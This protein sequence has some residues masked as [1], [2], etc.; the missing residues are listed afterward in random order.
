MGHDVGDELLKYVAARI[1][2]ILRKPDILARIGGDEFA[3][4]LHDTSEKD[5]ELVVA[6]I[7]DNVQRPFKVGNHT[8]KAD[9]SIGAAFY[10]ENGKSLQQLMRHADAAMY[11]AKSRGGGLTLYGPGSEMEN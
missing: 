8:L 7:L 10:P 11:L 9:L 3:I 2:S 6:R 4:L 1:G 5:V